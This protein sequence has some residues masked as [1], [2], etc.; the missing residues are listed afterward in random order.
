LAFTEKAAFIGGA[1][2]LLKDGGQLT[3]EIYFAGSPGL[4]GLTFAMNP[5]VAIAE[6]K[7]SWWT[8]FTDPQAHPILVDFSVPVVIFSV[9]TLLAR[10]TWTIGIHGVDEA[11][12]VIVQ[13]IYTVCFRARWTVRV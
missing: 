13:A 2:G 5:A 12:P 6:L 3:I 10:R 7:S 1:L 11:I 9:A 4:I 8:G